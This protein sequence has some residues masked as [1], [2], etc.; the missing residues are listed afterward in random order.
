MDQLQDLV[1]I[2]FKPMPATA[3]TSNMRSE[4]ACTSLLI[5]GEGATLKSSAADHQD[6]L[7]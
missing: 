5:T 3:A 6:M 1:S 4:T 7:P 2:S